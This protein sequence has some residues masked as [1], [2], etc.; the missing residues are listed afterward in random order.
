MELFTTF[1][2]VTENELGHTVGKTIVSEKGLTK[3]GEWR[4][5]KAV[6]FTT[7][8]EAVLGW[9]FLLHLAYKHST[10]FPISKFESKLLFKT[11]CVVRTQWACCQVHSDNLNL[12]F[13]YHIAL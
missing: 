1:Y 10:Y 4:N 12:V 5:K 9:F 13:I 7:R 6:N 11:S 2:P 3:A 8:L